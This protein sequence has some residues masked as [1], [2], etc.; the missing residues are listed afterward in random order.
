[1]SKFRLEIDLTIRQ[2]QFFRKLTENIFGHRNTVELFNII[3]QHALDFIYSE[4][5]EEE[6][7]KLFRDILARK[8]CDRNANFYHDYIQS[9]PNLKETK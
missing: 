7:I 9:H 8:S 5:N 2:Q 3:S 6:I 1:M 4:V